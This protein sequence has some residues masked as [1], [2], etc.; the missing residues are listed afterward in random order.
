MIVLP[1]TSLTHTH[2]A[3]PPRHISH[4]FTADGRTRLIHTHGLAINAVT[5]GTVVPH[6]LLTCSV[7]NIIICTSLVLAEVWNTRVVSLDIWQDTTGILFSFRKLSWDA[8]L[9]RHVGQQLPLRRTDLEQGRVG[10][11]WEKQCTCPLLQVQLW[12]GV[13]FHTSPSSYWYPAWLWQVCLAGRWGSCKDLSSSESKIGFLIG[14]YQKMH[15]FPLIEN[16]SQDTLILYHFYLFFECNR[17]LMY[18]IF[19][20]QDTSVPTLNFPY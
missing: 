6:P 3:A 15:L 5:L 12:Q 9:P 13:L 17:T 7:C 11:T 8:A 20:N 1:L 16:L 14:K 19:P 18:N 10:H 2:W 4:K